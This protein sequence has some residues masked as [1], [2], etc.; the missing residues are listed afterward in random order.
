VACQHLKSSLEYQLAL[1]LWKKI[2]SGSS[3][4]E[5]KL[6]TLTGTN[7]LDVISVACQQLK[8][9]LKISTGTYNLDGISQWH[10]SN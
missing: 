6:R 10:V 5:I 3:V 7:N 2:H 4:I 1:T 9:N 8:S